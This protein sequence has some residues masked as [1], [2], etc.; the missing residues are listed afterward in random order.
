MLSPKGSIVFF[1]GVKSFNDSSR[2]GRD[3]RGCQTLTDKKPP[4]SKSCFSS[5]SPVFALE[6]MWCPEREM[7]VYLAVEWRRRPFLIST[8]PY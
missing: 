8:H 5:R 7:K 4:R 6:G 3:E 2:L 1:K